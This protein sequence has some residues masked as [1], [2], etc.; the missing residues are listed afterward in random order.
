M[1]RTVK[2]EYDCKPIHKRQVFGESSKTI[3]KFMTGILTDKERKDE[4]Y[5]PYD[6]DDFERN[7]ALLLWYP[8]WKPRL[9]EMGILGEEWKNL[10]ENWS[11]IE[12]LYD[13]DYEKHGH[14]AFGEGECCKY[15]RS[16]VKN[17]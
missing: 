15:I 4:A 9:P 16:L 13:A 8:E 1:N 17:C 2:Q 14:K 11:I 7:R 3:F 10:V 12:K 5:Y 6:V